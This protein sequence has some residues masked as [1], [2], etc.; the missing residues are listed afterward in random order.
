[1]NKRQATE[2]AFAIVLVLV[3]PIFIIISIPIGLIFVIDCLLSKEKKPKDEIEKE[4]PIEEVNNIDAIRATVEEIEDLN[5]E[6]LEYRKKVD[7]RQFRGRNNVTKQEVADYLWYHY[8][9]EGFH[10]KRIICQEIIRVSNITQ[11]DIDWVFKEHYHHKTKAGE[12][13]SGCWIRN[14]EIRREIEY[15]NEKI[16]KQDKE[17]K[18]FMEREEKWMENFFPEINEIVKEVYKKENDE[19]YKYI[20]YYE[21]WLKEK[22]YV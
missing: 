15:E 4:I 18:E 16:R 17:N 21:E 10:E 5:K 7:L 11:D 2:I 22:G 13:G 14:E 9:W 1:M 3:N 20:F 12:E 8:L 19:K 6:D